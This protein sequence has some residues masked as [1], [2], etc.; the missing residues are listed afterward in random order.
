MPYILSSFIT[1]LDS[2]TNSL[3]EKNFHESDDPARVQRHI[4]F[5]ISR[6]NKVHKSY[7]R[8]GTLGEPAVG[9]AHPRGP[10]TLKTLHES[11]II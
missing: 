10:S 11:R 6:R 4:R 7:H 9:L 1:T 2:S 3:D 5:F 8:C